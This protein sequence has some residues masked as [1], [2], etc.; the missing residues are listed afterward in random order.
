[1]LLP[2][3]LDFG[4]SEFD[5]WSMTLG[6]IERLVASKTRM[7]K[8]EAQEKATFDYLQAILIVKGV[9]I[10]LG[11]KED[12][13]SIESIYPTLFVEEQ[14]QKQEKQEQRKTELSIL[15]FKQFAQTY[16]NSLKNKEV[17]QNSE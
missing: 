13:P 10:C 8:L 11:S 15:R 4:I 6:E 5:F 3:V 17:Q 7:R 16:N 14:T 2:R 9:G 12:F 1:M